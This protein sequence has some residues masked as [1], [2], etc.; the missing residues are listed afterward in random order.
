MSYNID[1]AT[2]S[3]IKNLYRSEK[4]FVEISKI[5]SVGDSTVRRILIKSGE[6]LR[7]PKESQIIA[8]KKGRKGYFLIGKKR[9]FTDEHKKNISISKKKWAAENLNDTKVNKSGYLVYTTVDKKDKLVHRYIVENFIGRKLTYDEVVHHKDFNKLNNSISNLKV[10]DRK[11]H[12]RLH[13]RIFYARRKR[14][15]K[16]QFTGD[17]L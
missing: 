16:G 10:M 4:T 2:L 3:L 8:G 12:N 14:D 7:T 17:V 5:T 1:E 6:K 11:D 9:A 15:K 13:A